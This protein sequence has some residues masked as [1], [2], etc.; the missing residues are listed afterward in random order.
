MEK[1][2]YLHNADSGY[3]DQ[4][5][6]EYK[7]DPASVSPT[8]RAFFEGFEFGSSGGPSIAGDT[9]DKRYEGREADVMR[10]IHGYR[11]RG[12]LVSKTN[13]VRQRRTH[14]A[15]LDHAIF[16]LTDEDL[17]KEFDIGDQIQIGRSSLRRIIEHLEETYCGSIGAEFAF[18]PDAGIRTW[19]R[20][21]L[22]RTGGRPVFG[23]SEKIHAFKKL[24]SSVQ[25]ENFLA[26]KYV[27]QKRFSLEG[28]ENFIPALDTIINAGADLGVREFN[29]GMA[30]RGRLNFLANIMGKGVEDIFSEFEGTD[31]SS[32]PFGQGDVKYHRGHSADIT[33]AN[34]HAV[35]LSLMSNPSHLEAIDPVIA[36]C[37]RAKA[38]KLYGGD[39]S[40][41]V[42][43]LV[44]GDASVAGQGVVYEVANLSRVEGYSTGGTIHI[45]INNQ[46]GFT[47]NYTETRSSTYCT[48]IA[49]AFQ[50]PVFHVNADD[51]EAMLYVAR[52]AIEIR[53]KFKVDVFI[54]IL[55]YRRHGHNEGDDPKFTQPLLYKAIDAHPSVL[56]VYRK[57][58]VA[59]QTLSD[60]DADKLIAEHKAHLQEKHTFAKT[61]HHGSAVSFLQR[62]WMNLRTATDNDFETSPQTG[63][64]KESL[65][66]VGKALTTLPEGF[67]LY[68][69]MKKI[70]EQRGAL[71]FKE[72]KAD[73]AIAEQL[74]FGSLLIEDIPVRLSG[75]DCR[76]GT[77]SHRHAVLMDYEEER[78][79]TPLNH[80]QEKQ[81]AFSVYNSILSEYGVMGFEFGYSLASPR[82]L[83]IWE[84]QFGDFANGAQVMIDQFLCS[85]ESKWQRMSGLTLLLPH[86]YEG[87]GPEHSSAR[88]ERYLQLCAEHNMVVANITTPAN[89]FH[90]LRRQAVQPFRKPLV[91]MSPKSL[92]R[93]PEVISPLAELVSGSFREFID[94]TS[95]APKKAKRVVFCSGKLYY[96]LAAMR[97]KTKRDDVAIVRIEQLYPLPP[98]QLANLLKRYDKATDFAWVQEEP[99]NMGAW[100]YLLR[101]FPRP[102]RYIGRPEAASTAPG[103]H[104]KYEQEQKRIVAE[105][106]S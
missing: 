41:I 33:T 9:R 77:F 35:H 78:S 32:I 44:H 66:S 68:P 67:T 7:K 28:A 69:K 30:H 64:A 80:I 53:Q 52:K 49:K 51:T 37:T 91:V 70:I 23:N 39:A 8:W 106:F 98:K 15:E 79:H 58:L 40:K 89:F 21:E 73:W 61:K 90:L 1:F 104:D 84:A 20:A 55:G 59:E 74:A 97:A 13:P 43:I 88:L 102:L 22:E 47:A 17:D 6:Q 83:V 72:N 96:E 50:C 99:E 60:A 29:I 19:I 86:G 48:D 54:D 11:S 85:S 10:L 36:G 71:L 27:G 100:G 12:H 38:E 87:Q 75:Q 26:V 3:V 24:I 18:L 76:R 14:K 2:S 95:V 56:D 81:A 105:A 94:D 57:K 4:L 101:K 42:P 82:S 62:Q 93:H 46:I 16:N 63:V 92:L 34:G 45:V 25:F 103:M 65:F 5:F 31:S